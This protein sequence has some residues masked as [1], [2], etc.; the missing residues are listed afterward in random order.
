VAF[1]KS[2]DIPYALEIGDIKKILRAVEGLYPIK[3]KI[4]DPVSSV[5]RMAKI[6]ANINLD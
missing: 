6:G 3:K 1:T 4:I 2:S 5:R